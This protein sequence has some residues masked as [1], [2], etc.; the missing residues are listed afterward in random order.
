MA[1]SKF[2]FLSPELLIRLAV[3]VVFLSEGIQ[4]FLFPALG[5]VGDLRR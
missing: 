5:V 1:K 3:G 4:K 2:L